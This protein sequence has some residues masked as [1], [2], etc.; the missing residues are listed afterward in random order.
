M[1]QS[2]GLTT[3]NELE[4]LLFEGISRDIFRGEIS[5]AKS[6]FYVSYSR[7]RDCLPNEREVILANLRNM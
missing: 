3:D 2:V 5:Q 7:A 6:K 1:K 4:E